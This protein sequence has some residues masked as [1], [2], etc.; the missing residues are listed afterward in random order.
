LKQQLEESQ[1]AQ[2]RLNKKLIALTK[3]GA[4][5]RVK[6]YDERQSIIAKEVEK[7]IAEWKSST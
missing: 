1:K 3:L 6:E 7:Q 4:Y 5:R 2:E